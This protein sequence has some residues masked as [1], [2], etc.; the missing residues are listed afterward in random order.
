MVFYKLKNNISFSKS[1]FSLIEVLL[2]LVI[3]FLIIGGVISFSAGTIESHM[4]NQAM[5]NAM[6]NARFAIEA[7]SKKMRTSSEVAGG[8][9]EIFFR[10][11]VDAT[12]YCYEFAT[13][14]DGN[15]F[16]QV[17]SYPYVETDANYDSV[18]NCS[19]IS[20]TPKELVGGENLSVT[21]EF[22]LKGTNDDNDKRGFVRIRVN[23]EQDSDGGGI[24]GQDSVMIQTGVSLRDY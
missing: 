19:D 4:K 8:D 20:E 11:N 5:Q 1:G 23:I 15:G 7:M 9:Q 18:S 13:N 17:K 6:D 10:D 2:S 21:G 3:L 24:A 14:A 16:L 22:S 12:K